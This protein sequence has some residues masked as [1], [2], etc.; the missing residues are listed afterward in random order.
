VVARGW[1]IPAVVGAE[2]VEVEDGTIA[3]GGRLFAAGDLLTIDGGKGRVFAGDLAGEATVVPEAEILLGWAR[4]LGIDL[5]ESGEGSAEMAASDETTGDIGI[6]MRDLAIR[7]L[8]IKGFVT[9]DGFAPILLTTE[10]DAGA[11]LGRLAADDLAE[12]TGPMFKLTSDGTLV[13]EEMMAADREAWG[14]EKAGAALDEFVPIDQRMKHIVTA[15]Q[16]REVD[17]EPVMNDHTD[18]EYDAGVL[19]DFAALHTEA[20]PWV[21]SLAEGL[22]RLDVYRARLDRAAAQVA[23]GDH[24]YIASPRIDSYHNVWFELHEDLIRLAGRTRE[25][26]VAAGRA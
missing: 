24:A 14:V 3:I 21:G 15:W 6:P 13:G 26:E 10:E 22:S 17:G 23:E 16:M 1:G 11:E 8:L 19:A 2:G 25:D 12:M 5:G 7:A 20:R 9:P 4:E 18:A